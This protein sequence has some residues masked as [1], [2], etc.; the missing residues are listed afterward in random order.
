MLAKKTLIYLVKHGFLHHF[1]DHSMAEHSGAR[2]QEIFQHTYVLILGGVCFQEF[3]GTAIFLAISKIVL[4]SK[5]S[6]SCHKQ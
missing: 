6:V 3:S 4:L 1:F 5:F 2:G